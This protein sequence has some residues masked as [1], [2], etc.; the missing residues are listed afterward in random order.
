MSKFIPLAKKLRLGKKGKQ[1]RWAPFWTVPKKFPKG[2]K[3]HP[4]SYTAVKRNWRRKKTKAQNGNERKRK[5]LCNSSKKR[6]AKG[7]YLQKKLKSNQS[8]K[9]ICFKAY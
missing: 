5:K 7:S 8:N 6:V 3:V 2:K 9:R 1:T 4:S